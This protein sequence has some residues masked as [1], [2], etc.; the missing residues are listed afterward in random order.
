MP[1]ALVIGN[2]AWDRA[3]RCEGGLPAAGASVHG[4]VVAE[5]PGGK[6]LNQATVPARAGVETRLL[7]A[8]GRGDLGDRLAAEAPGGGLVRVGAPT[9]WT[10]ALLGR[11]ENAVVTTRDP[12]AGLTPAQVE[13]ALGAAAPGDL[14]VPQGNLARAATGAAVVEARRRGL[15]L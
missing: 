8:V 2:A 12:D 15:A 7:A 14:C 9:D 4:R 3:V 1:R 13:G 11:G 6:G 5:G 10:V